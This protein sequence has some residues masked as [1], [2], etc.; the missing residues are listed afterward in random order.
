MCS[1]LLHSLKVDGCVR[2][3]VWMQMMNINVYRVS[4]AAVISFSQ[5]SLSQTLTVSEVCGALEVS[6]HKFNGLLCVNTRVF[7]IYMS[8]RAG[9]K[10]V[11]TRYIFSSAGE[12][13]I[14]V[15]FI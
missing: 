12:T 2:K 7:W 8:T 3:F 4:S 5:K 15:Q 6:C 11:H 1:V 14:I 9:E 10:S 13:R